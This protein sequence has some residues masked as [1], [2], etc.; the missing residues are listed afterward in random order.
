MST[1]DEQLK[2]GNDYFYIFW[3]SGD[4]Y[5]FQRFV[6]KM[7][8]PQQ[9]GLLPPQLYPLPLPR[10]LTPRMEQSARRKESP[11][12]KYAVRYTPHGCLLAVSERDH[13]PILIDEI[14]MSH[15]V[16]LSRLVQMFS[17]L[18]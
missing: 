3:L 5:F 12:A 8:N 18:F 13:C 11:S 7:A 4:F 1:Q 9:P 14:N 15:C 10:Y 6:E 16:N 2:S 17:H